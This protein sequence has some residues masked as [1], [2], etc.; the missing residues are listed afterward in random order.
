MELTRDPHYSIR[1]AAESVREYNHRTIDGP[2]AFYGEHPINTAPP[3]IGEAIGAL[4][5]LFER[6]PQ[7]VDQTAAAVRHV[8]EQEAI[9]MANDD[10]PGEAVSRLLRAL[11]DARQSMLLAQTHLRSAVQVSSNLAGHWL[12]DADDGDFEGVGVIG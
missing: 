5:T 2:Q 11:I 1:A 8:E 4:Y 10:D 9:R 7:A 12:D 6:L 3:A